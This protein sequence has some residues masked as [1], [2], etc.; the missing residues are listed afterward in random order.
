MVFS[1]KSSHLELPSNPVTQDSLLPLPQLALTTG[2]QHVVGDMEALAHESCSESTGRENECKQA[3]K[4]ISRNV[5]WSQAKK[6]NRRRECHL[7][8]TV[9]AESGHQC[10]QHCP[11]SHS[12]AQCWFWA[13]DTWGGHHRFDEIP[14]V[15]L[16]EFF[17]LPWVQAIMH[18]RV[19]VLSE[20]N[21]QIDV[22]WWEIPYSWRSQT[23]AIE[24]N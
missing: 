3:Q 22:H 2:K 21:K 24:C 4:E 19:H 9:D 8:G 12:L 5:H 11:A 23:K 15:L 14:A 20:C 17:F 13:Q 1:R 10:A 18:W 6:R 7:A 16:T